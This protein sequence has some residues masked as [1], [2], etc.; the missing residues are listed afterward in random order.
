MIDE[1]CF[2][3]CQLETSHLRNDDVVDLSTRIKTYISSQL[4]SSC[5]FW[6]DHVRATAVTPG[7]EAKV[8]AFFETKILYWLEVLSLIKKVLDALS[9]LSSTMEWGKVSAQVVKSSYVGLMNPRTQTLH[10]S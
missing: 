1:L 9:A 2:N 4:S 7:L 3:I 10:H 6:A 5:R 8:K